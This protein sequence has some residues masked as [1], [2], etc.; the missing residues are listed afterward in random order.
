MARIKK[1]VISIT[2]KNFYD[3]AWINVIVIDGEK[4][5]LNCLHPTKK[6]ALKSYP[7]LVKKENRKIV[8]VMLVEFAHLNFKEKL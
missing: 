6:D 2:A 4:L 7:R 1:E 8:K 3:S 5:V